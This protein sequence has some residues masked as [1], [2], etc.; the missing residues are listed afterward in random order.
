VQRWVPM[1][2]IS[3]NLIHAV[4]LREDA[5]FFEHEGLDWEEVQ[6]SAHTNL[7]RLRLVRGGSTLTQQLAKNLFLSTRK[8]PLRKLRE[9][10]ATRWLEEDLPKTRILELYLNVIEWGE[11]VYGC[12]AAAILYYGKAAAGLSVVEA[13]GLAAII[14]SPRKL[15]PLANP[16]RHR[17]AQ[18]RVLRLLETDRYV[19]ERVRRL[20]ATPPP[21][22]QQ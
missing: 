10:V 4:V 22:P 11:G 14:P 6:K 21:V 8:D 19:V 1:S 15:N 13:A 12:E 9:I 2:G 18:Q 16:E 17:R 7:R 5:K 20:G 3:R